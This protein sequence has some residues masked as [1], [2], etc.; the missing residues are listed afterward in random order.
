[1][2]DEDINIAVRPMIAADATAEQVDSDRLASG[3]ICEGVG[4]LP[5]VIVD[6]DHWAALARGPEYRG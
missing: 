1:V 3:P 2:L 5:Q 6:F 4:K